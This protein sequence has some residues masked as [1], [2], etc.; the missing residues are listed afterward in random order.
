MQRIEDDGNN[1]QLIRIRVEKSR[2]KENESDN[3]KRCLCE[4]TKTSQKF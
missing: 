2:Y 1:K 4:K 3:Y